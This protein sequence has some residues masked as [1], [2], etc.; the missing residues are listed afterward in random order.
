MTPKPITKL[1]EPWLIS[2]SLAYLI[3]SMAAHRCILGA[4]GSNIEPFEATNNLSEQH[5]TTTQLNADIFESNQSDP[6]KF[7][8]S[9]PN[10]NHNDIRDLK[11][12]LYMRILATLACLIIFIIGVSGNLLVPLVVIKT[13][14]LR[15]ST[16]LFLINLSIADLLVLIV[17]MPTVFIELHTKPETWLLGEPMCKYNP[18]VPKFN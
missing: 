2:I 5:T 17:C 16:N 1:H 18:N 12:P 4:D 6:N 7:I 9:S 13:K 10:M 11:L 3:V 15:N 8:T 14:Y